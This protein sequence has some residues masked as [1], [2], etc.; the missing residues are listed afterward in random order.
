MTDLDAVNAETNVPAVVVE[1]EVDDS[2][3]ARAQHGGGPVLG[4]WYWVTN[5]T[6]HNGKPQSDWLGCAMHIG[7]NY[8][9]IHSPPEDR[10]GNTYVRVHFDDFWTNLR[11]E[12][13]AVE[14]IRQRV[15][16]WQG[17]TMRLMADIEA[18][19]RSLGMSRHEAIGN[20]SGGGA[21]GALMVLSSQAEPKQY[22]N[23]L[24]LAKEKTLPALFKELKEA[25]GGLAKWLKAP[26]L[27]MQANVRDQRELIDE[28]D[29]RVF[30]VSLY[31]GLTE[32]AVQIA[33]GAPADMLDRLHVMQRMAL[34]DE[35]CLANYRTG[36]M[37]FKDIAAFDAWLAEPENRDRILPFPRTLVAMRVRRN[38]KER[39]WQGSIRTLHVQLQDAEQDKATFLYVRNGAQLWRIQTAIDFGELIFPD[40]SVFD[41]KEPKMIR[42]WGSYSIKGFIS[43]ARY[44]QMVAE[45]AA[46]KVKQDEWR[47]N[48]KGTN[49]W[50][51]M[52][53]ALRTPHDDL[54][55]YHPFDPSSVYYDDASAE[56]AKQ[57]K[58]YN[59]VA[60]IIQGLFDRSMT[61][62][63][64]PKANTWTAEGFDAAVKL[65]YDGTSVLHYGEPPDFEAYRARCN[66]SLREGSMTIGQDDAWARA[67]AVKECKRLDND[68]RDKG[69]YRPERFRPSGNPGPG[70]IA[71][72]AKWTRTGRAT[73]EWQ[74]E[75]RGRGTWGEVRPASITLPAAEL[76]NVDAYRPGDFKQ[77]FADPRSRAQYLKWAPM[78]IAAEEFH[79]Q[80]AKE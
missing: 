13:N 53:Y 67:E 25:N 16:H 40:P 7:S 26:M 23:A 3:F 69:N 14:V 9:E 18:V 52:P 34:M 6:D 65:V 28:I 77:F 45:N 27:P 43:V 46:M 17:E 42:M 4:Q 56:I 1:A 50:V 47:A 32:E 37:E 58:Q 11:H 74:R 55:D 76:F 57:V 78:L 68:W 22:A 12:P 51:D 29:D 38:V 59:R 2:K 48:Y 63:P 31:A 49:A 64:H 54:R 20:A 72:V 79:A 62:H 39:D 44:E 21:G 73:F 35:E 80:K 41:P 71:R 60:L 36:G 5:R 15:G 70:Y 8:V 10:G 61:L 19:T 66:E 24:T 30:S 75:L 33:E